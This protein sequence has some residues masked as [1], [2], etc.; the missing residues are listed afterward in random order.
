MFSVHSLLWQDALD[1]AS[2]NTSNIVDNTG[3]ILN[4]A[5]KLQYGD[6][7]QFKTLHDRA[8]KDLLKQVALHAQSDLTMDSK[9]RATWEIEELTKNPDW[10]AYLTL[11]SEANSTEVTQ[12]KLDLKANT[13]A[14]LQEAG[15]TV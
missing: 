12:L 11:R 13:L 6:G 9:D 3:S 14:V 10:L 8:K 5:K 4:A 2:S 15:I 7:K 1:K